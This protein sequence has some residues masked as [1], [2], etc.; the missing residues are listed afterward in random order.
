MKSGIGNLN[1]CKDTRMGDITTLAISKM[2]GKMEWKAI[3]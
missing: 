1:F 3:R 2:L